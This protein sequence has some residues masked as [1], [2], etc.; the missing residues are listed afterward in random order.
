[1]T[2]GAERKE[3][4][5]EKLLFSRKTPLLTTADTDSC[6]PQTMYVDVDLSFFIAL[7]IIIFNEE[8]IIKL[9]VNGSCRV[10]PGVQRR[11]SHVEELKNGSLLAPWPGVK[12]VLATWWFGR[13]YGALVEPVGILL[14]L[15]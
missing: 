3:T 8:A 5:E 12:S 4:P 11:P 7:S 9:L 15:L 1:M 6:W 2:F 14:L 13:S 10:A